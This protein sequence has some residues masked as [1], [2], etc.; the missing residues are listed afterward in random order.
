MSARCAGC[1]AEWVGLK[2]AHC[3]TCHRT[4]TSVDAFDRHRIGSQAARRCDV[5]GMRRNRRGHYVRGGRERR[6]A[7]TWATGDRA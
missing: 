4:F 7:S 6:A 3:A 5:S 2:L 1:G